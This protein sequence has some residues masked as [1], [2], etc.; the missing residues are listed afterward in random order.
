MKSKK[1]VMVKDLTHK[2]LR[3]ELES[4]AIKSINTFDAETP[5]EV[6]IHRG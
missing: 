3:E 6:M 5:V 4:F 1:I 2:D